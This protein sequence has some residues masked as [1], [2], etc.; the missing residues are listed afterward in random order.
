MAG[1][2]QQK[3]PCPNSPTREGARGPAKDLARHGAAVP[4]TGR[5]FLAKLLGRV[6]QFLASIASF[7]CIGNAVDFSVA[8]VAN[9]CEGS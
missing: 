3:R 7:G 4:P 9:G 6:C 8:G 1:A 2:S 5:S